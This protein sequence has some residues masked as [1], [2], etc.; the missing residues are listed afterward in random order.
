MSL[1]LTQ[2]TSG[3]VKKP[4]ICTVYGQPGVGKTSLASEFPKPVFICTESGTDNLDVFRLPQ[5]QTWSDLL[6]MVDELLTEKHDFKTLVIDSLDF[7]EPL[8][9]AEVCK[10]H[11]VKSVSDLTYGKGYAAALEKWQFLFKKLSSLKEKMNVVFTL[12]MASSNERFL[13]KNPII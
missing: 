11:N 8:S 10:E 9:F 4:L 12:D 3:K 7:A 2:V 1:F 5:P 13:F 6:N